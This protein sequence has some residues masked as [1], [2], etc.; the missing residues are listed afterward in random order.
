MEKKNRQKNNTGW[1]GSIRRFKKRRDTPLKILEWETKESISICVNSLTP[2]DVIECH[3][4]LSFNIV[5]DISKN[6]AY[7]YMLK[8]ISKGEKSPN[9][10]LPWLFV[11]KH[12]TRMA[13][14][15][16]RSIA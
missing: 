3:M 6:I 5:S 13:V 10:L 16:G 2:R 15:K 1:T 11:T 7:H 14:S 9:I 8:A 12:D 4:F